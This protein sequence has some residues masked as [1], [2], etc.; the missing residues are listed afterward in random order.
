MALHRP[1]EPSPG[2]GNSG[3]HLTRGEKTQEE[4]ASGLPAAPRA[5]SKMQPL[6]VSTSWGGCLCELWFLHPL[7][8]KIQLTPSVPTTPPGWVRVLGSAGA[9]PEAPDGT[10]SPPAPAEHSGWQ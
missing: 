10:C 2:H 8:H 7:K 6:R 9:S 5:K 3:P 4:L 1:L